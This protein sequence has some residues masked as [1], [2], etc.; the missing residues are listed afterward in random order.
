[1]TGARTDDSRILGIYRRRFSVTPAFTPV[2]AQ[3]SM[4][5]A[6]LADI[7]DV[8]RG[9]FD[10]GRGGRTDIAEVRRSDR[11]VARADDR[12]PRRTNARPGQ[13]KTTLGLTVD[14][15]DPGDVLSPGVTA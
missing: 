1:M 8:E 7:L 11:R 4:R 10:D 12:G 15:E 9:V 5:Y 14:L 6:T 3:R 13:Q 2:S